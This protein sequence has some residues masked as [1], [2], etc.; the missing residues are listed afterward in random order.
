MRKPV[1]ASLLAESLMM[2]SAS[3]LADEIVLENGDRMTGTII[4]KEGDALRMDTSYAGTVEIKWLQVK[5]IT[6][7][8]TVRIILE[9]DSRVNGTLLEA[10]EGSLRLR[11]D[12]GIEGGP[13]PLARVIYINPPPEVDG[14]VTTTGKLNLGINVSKGNTD[15]EDVHF[16]G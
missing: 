10:P 2:A 9:D 16:N 3:A 12:D 1:L 13:I 14:A 15:T 7:E 5:Q 6:T 11:S 4:G 8:K